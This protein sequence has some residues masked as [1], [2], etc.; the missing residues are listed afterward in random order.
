MEPREGETAGIQLEA[1]EE[2]NKERN[3]RGKNKTWE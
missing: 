1:G 3:G 2:S